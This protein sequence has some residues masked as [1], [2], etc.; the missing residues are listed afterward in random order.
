MDGRLSDIQVGLDY[1]FN[2]RMAVG[3][4]YN[5][6][7]MDIDASETGGYEGTVDWAYDGFVLYFKLDLGSQ[8][9]PS[10]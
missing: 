5:D 1:R 7:S 10:R 8:V 6:V 9:L 2:E 3:L 4:S